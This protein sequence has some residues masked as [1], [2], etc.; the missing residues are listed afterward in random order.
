MQLSLEA[1]VRRL[2][3]PG[4]TLLDR[5]E[6]VRGMGLVQNKD[7]IPH[8][9]EA[10]Q[11]EELKV[12]AI[13]ALGKYTRVSDEAFDAVVSEY[14]TAKDRQ[15]KAAIIRV[16][17]EYVPM[18]KTKVFE[19]LIIM[20][21]DLEFKKQLYNLSFKYCDEN[22]LRKISMSILDSG[23][24]EM[25]LSAIKFLSR[26]N[27]PEIIEK[28]FDL[29]A[30]DDSEVASYALRILEDEFGD[31]ILNKFIDRIRSANPDKKVKLVYVLGNLT[32]PKVVAV[33]AK[34][35]ISTKNLKLRMAA[36]QALKKVANKSI[37]KLLYKMFD[38][39]TDEEKAVVVEI[40]SVLKSKLLKEKVI[41]FAESVMGVDVDIAK[42]IAEAGFFS[43]SDVKRYL[44]SDKPTVRFAAILSLPSAEF[45]TSEI[46]SFIGELLEK[47]KLTAVERKELYFII[48]N[49]GMRNLS[50]LLRK[51]L[52]AGSDDE[53]IAAMISISRLGLEDMREMV[54]RELRENE[55]EKVRATAVN[56]LAAIGN[57]NSAMLL[58]KSLEDDDARVRANAVEALEELFKKG[59]LSEKVLVDNLIK[60]LHDSNN[61]VKANAAMVLW[62]VGGV[63]I[64]RVLEDM[65]LTSEHM[66]HRA[67]AAFALGETKSILAIGILEKAAKDPD[68]PVRRNVAKA[69]GKIKDPACIE[70]LKILK[71]D[72]ALDV[73]VEVANALGNIG[74]VQAFNLLVHLASHPDD[75]VSSAAIENAV[76][77]ASKDF[78][79]PEV[80]RDLFNRLP[81]LALK[82]VG[83]FKD[84][85]FVATVKKFEK[86]ENALL[87]SVASEVLKELT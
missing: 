11:E 51:P 5:K 75:R 25:K 29:T 53:K 71:D 76:K 6:A 86:S 32:T 72:P 82:L 16:L 54:E 57:E 12:E 3:T 44:Q 50:H 84:R 13:E 68:S 56:T 34:V 33:L 59:Y 30:S 14:Y 52:E 40:A 28:M 74:G 43:Q 1:L 18:H 42:S 77:V 61:R 41:S 49:F 27:L 22:T 19:K 46:E 60:M 37:E 65:L 87:A 79:A 80:I 67:S 45:D 20:E 26:F 81:L 66:W 23:D 9:M 35:L 62:R 10:L 39:L 70:V 8:L 17:S 31:E 36:L 7:A 85:S 64:L 58:L 38:V 21:D 24:T 15:V 55:N 73:L 83:K 48:G 47:A 2:K 69:L 63:G 78:V 4:A